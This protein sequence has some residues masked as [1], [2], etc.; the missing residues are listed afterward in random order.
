[1]PSS[2]LRAL[3][4]GPVD[5][6]KAEGAGYPA[7]AAEL[8]RKPLRERCDLRGAQATAAQIE[9]Y[10]RERGYH[11]ECKVVPAAYNSTLR[12]ARYDV[13]SSL[14]NGFPTERLTMRGR[15]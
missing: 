13:R 15:G 7:T 10:W 9:R 2:P 3:S 6:S 4:D 1:M 12:L 5:K 14:R 8:P 11:V